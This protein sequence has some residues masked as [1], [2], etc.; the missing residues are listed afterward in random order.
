MRALCILL[1]VGVVVVACS[2]SDDGGATSS[3]G[4]APDGGSSGTASSTSSSGGGSSGGGSTNPP[5]NPFDPKLAATKVAIEVDYEDG[6]VPY[7]GNTTLF[8]DTWKLFTTNANALFDGTNRALAIPTTVDAFEK[9][10]D[11]PAATTSFDS[12]AILAIAA[13]HRQTVTS[14]DTIAY[15]FLWL[16]GTFTQNGGPDPN[17]LGV[18]LGNTGVLAM[19]KPV[20]ES[21]SQG[22]LVPDANHIVEQVVLTHEFGHAVGLVNNGVALSSQHQDTAHGAHCSNEKCVMYW[23]VDGSS[24]ALDFA[25]KN[26]TGQNL[27]LFADDCLADVSAAK[28]GH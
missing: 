10:T 28:K 22:S 9:L 2:S 8:G 7:T 21:A 23:S 4:A 16:N 1:G 25:T 19:F 27:V 14:N 13:K 11:I 6:A 17:I 3:G 12:D 20:I 24:A 26:V 5:A 18:S 15:Y